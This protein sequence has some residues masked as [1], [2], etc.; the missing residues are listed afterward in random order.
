MSRGKRGEYLHHM[1]MIMRT[2]DDD[3]DGDEDDDD[4]DQVASG[5]FK[6]HSYNLNDI[7]R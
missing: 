3:Y 5:N 4:D 1:M 6:V 7:W 2:N